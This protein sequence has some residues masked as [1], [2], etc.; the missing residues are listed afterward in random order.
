MDDKRVLLIDGHS[1]ANRA[2]YALP[3]LS[4]AGGTPTNAVYGFLTMV[5]KFLKERNCKYALCAFDYPAPTFRHAKFD[6][7]KAT[8]KPAPP[9]F[10]VQIPLIK[11]VLNALRIKSFEIEGYEADDIIGT[12]ASKL[13]EQGFSVMILSG[14]RDCLQLVNEKITVVI[15]VQGIR[16]VMEFDREKVKQ[17]IGVFPE[18]IPDYK[19]LAGDHSDNIPGV[20]GVGEKTAVALL[21]KF[22]SVEG[23]YANLENV[24]P[25]RLRG[26]LQSSRD[27]AF[28]SRELAVIHTGVPLQVDPDELY[29]RGPDMEEAPKILREL[30]FSSLIPKLIPEMPRATVSQTAD[31]PHVEHI[32]DIRGLEEALKACLESGAISLCADHGHVG[33]IRLWP[34][35]IGISSGSRHFVINGA[36]EGDREEALAHYLGKALG[37][38]KITK[39]GHDLKW[40][41]ALS[42]LFRFRVDGHVFDE[43]IAQYLLDP[44]RSSYPAE[45]AVRRFGGIEL[46]ESYWTMTEGPALM[47]FGV[48]KAY[49]GLKAELSGSGLL[50]LAEE[51]EFPL[52]QV[53]ADMEVTGVKVDLEKAKELSWRFAEEMAMIEANIWQMA[54]EKF[55]LG[56]PKQLA[57]VLFDRLGLKPVKKTKT[58]YSTDAEVLE[59]L[60][61]ENDLPAKILEYRQYAK[62]KSTYLDGL[63]SQVNPITGRVH[64]TFNQTGTATGR[65]SSS[66]PNL[67]NI[68]ARSDLGK[69]IRQ[70]FVAGEDKLFLASD[71]SQIELRIMAHMSGDPGLIGAFKRGEDIHART[72]AEMFGV[73]L[74]DVTS[75]LRSRA[76]AVNFGIIYGI[77][78]FGLAR[79]TG[80][81]REEARKFIEAYFTRY[82]KV[83]EYMDSMVAKAREVGYVTTIMG[84]R[85]PI[86][87]ISSRVFSKRSFAERT[88]INSPIQGSAADIIKIAMVR[89]FNRLKREGLSS[90]IVL[91]I[92]DELVFEILPSEEE[93]LKQLVRHEM[94]NVM[95]LEVPL[96]VDIAVG[97]SLYQV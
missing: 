84:R 23:I 85:R 27:D 35:K 17:E 4:T 32:R 31:L 19:G 28:L 39:L 71:Y 25:E 92:H 2:Y 91:Q 34:S 48:F 40:V 41:F 13:S 66:E 49:P 26:L 47:A 57:H 14:D 83:K 52:I 60:A 79:N 65:L 64:T 33:L 11:K 95:S 36:F 15:P 9:D 1:L 82:P 53:L 6:K 38:P 72:A 43:C 76:K 74:Q 10:K 68:P 12:A 69:L 55:N 22:G 97:G 77:S 45:D 37:D 30:E 73:K 61:E 16:S 78:D 7:Y 75:E 96:V 63:E 81:K 86:P 18:Q 88:A 8:R 87:D 90:K 89:I 59:A 20:K 93:Y 56:S 51:V 46:P 94:E 5:L 24:E 54:G 3:P 21:D 58:G 42:S 50:K 80:V 29:W 70:V 67:Q 44:T 62:L